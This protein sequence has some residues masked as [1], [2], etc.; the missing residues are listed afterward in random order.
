MLK[1]YRDRTFISLQFKTNKTIIFA[2]FQR[3]FKFL[4]EKRESFGEAKKRNN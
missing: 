1:F 2:N 3:T 4:I